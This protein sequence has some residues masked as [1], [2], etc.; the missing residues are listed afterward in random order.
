[1]AYLTC[2]RCGLEIKIRAAFL[3]IENCPRCL[4]RSAIVSPLVLST[5]ALT[6][7]AGWSPPASDPPSPQAIDPPLVDPGAQIGPS[8]QQR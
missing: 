1:M 2:G 4:A 6:P 3:R 8:G 7:A 5:R